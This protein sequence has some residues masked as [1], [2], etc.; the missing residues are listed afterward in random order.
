MQSRLN[1]M[2]LLSEK[3]HN[4][5]LFITRSNFGGYNSLFHGGCKVANIKKRRG[6]V[7]ATG[8]S[9]T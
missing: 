9:F 5:G 6:S 2:Y 4:D 8:S 1:S 7:I 3:A